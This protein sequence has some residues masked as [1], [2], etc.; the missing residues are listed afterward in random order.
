MGMMVADR[1]LTMTEGSSLFGG[2]PNAFSMA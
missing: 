2:G 1:T